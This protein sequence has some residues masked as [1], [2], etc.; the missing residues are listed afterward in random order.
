MYCP[1]LSGFPHD[2][3]DAQNGKSSLVIKLGKPR[4]MEH[5][6]E[7]ESFPCTIVYFNLIHFA[8]F[9]YF[10][11]CVVARYNIF[12]GTIKITMQPFIRFT[13]TNYWCAILVAG[14]FTFLRFNS[15]VRLKIHFRQ[16][17]FF[18]LGPE[19]NSMALT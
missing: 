10:F 7:F 17:S 13:V 6:L 3:C 1:R 11:R 12:H 8:G 18:V 5:D 16:L 2:S 15:E 14:V 9:P 4:R 19:I